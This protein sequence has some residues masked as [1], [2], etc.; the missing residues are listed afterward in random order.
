MPYDRHIYYP[1]VKIDAIYLHYHIATIFIYFKQLDKVIEQYI[2]S[3]LFIISQ[4]NKLSR[5]RV[6]N[7]LR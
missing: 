7:Y 2:I 3:V 6:N 5:D 1:I 4:K